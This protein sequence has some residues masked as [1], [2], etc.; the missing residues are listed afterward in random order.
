M[1]PIYDTLSLGNGNDDF[2]FSFFIWRK[3]TLTA[4]IFLMFKQC[5]FGQVYFIYG[6]NGAML[7][8]HRKENSTVSISSF[9]STVL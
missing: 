9:L 6:D 8:Y 2:C 1:N 5:F 3:F 7:Y 4:S